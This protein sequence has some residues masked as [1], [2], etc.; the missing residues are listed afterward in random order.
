MI[1]VYFLV[2]FKYMGWGRTVI[3]GTAHQLPDKGSDR[4]P[5]SPVKW[6]WHRSSSGRT[7]NN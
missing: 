7:Y 3:S 2:K 4:N 5:V 1:D 6:P